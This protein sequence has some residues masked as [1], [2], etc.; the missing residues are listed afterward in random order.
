[1]QTY[2]ISVPLAAIRL[3]PST[4]SDKAG[5]LDSLPSDAIVEIHGPS[6]LGH[7]MIEVSWQRRRYAVFERDLAARAV[8]ESMEEAVGD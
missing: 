7:G 5:V 4:D 3:C 2:T 6:D 1:M 8:P